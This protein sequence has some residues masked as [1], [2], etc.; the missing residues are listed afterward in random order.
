MGWW[1]L[2]R[3]GLAG[4]LGSRF[5][6][7]S[8]MLGCRALGSGAVGR[9]LWG[10]G[11]VG[12]GAAGLA[13][14]LGSEFFLASLWV[15]GRGALG[16]QAARSGVVSSRVAGSGWGF[17]GLPGLSGY[18]S[19]NLEVCVPALGPT[20]GSCECRGPADPP[21]RLGPVAVLTPVQT[22][23]EGRG[24]TD[25]GQSTPWLKPSRSFLEVPVRVARQL[26]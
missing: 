21:G 25:A 11:V 13:R 8:G 3:R 20:P 26:G 2:G 14:V 12:S 19:Q 17:W 15:A 22:P 9:W 4:A 1:V 5:C 24:R 6:L 10:S 18:G 23:C 16:R 7:T